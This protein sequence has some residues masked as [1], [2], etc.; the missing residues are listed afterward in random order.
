MW[1]NITTN[2]GNKH[3]NTDRYSPRRSKAATSSASVVTGGPRKVPHLNFGIT[4]NANT[5]EGNFLEKTK[6]KRPM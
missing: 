3:Q 4:H 2:H 5:P 6:L 1:S